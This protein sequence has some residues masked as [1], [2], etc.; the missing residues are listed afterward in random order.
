MSKTLRVAKNSLWLIVQPV[1]LNLLSLLAVPYIARV[2]GKADYGRFILGFAFV[3]MFSPLVNMG[4]RAITVRDLAQNR[5]SCREY[6][7]KMLGT[8]GLLGLAASGAV[9]VVV[10]I[11]GYDSSTKVVVYLAALAMLCE[12]VSGTLQDVFQAVEDM[13]YTAYSRFVGGFVLTVLSVVVVLAGWG[14]V[15]LTCS[16]LF[17][18]V[19]TTA[20]A[21][22]YAH[23]LM[24]SPSVAFDWAFTKASLVRGA[25]FFYP[26][27]VSAVAARIGVSLLPL[28]C[29]VAAVGA[30]GAASTLME[31]L[32]VIPDGICTAIYPSL[33]ATYKTS[34]EEAASLFRRYF[35]YLFL[36][37]LPVAV[38]ATLIAEPVIMLLF[39]KQYAAAAPVLAILSWWVFIMFLVQLLGWT[40]GAIQQE[41]RIAVVTFVTAPLGV[42]LTLALIPYFHEQGIAWAKVG[43][44]VLDLVLLGHCVR[45]TLTR[46]IL[47][48]RRLV[49]LVL[50]NALMGLLVGFVRNMNIAIP[51]AVGVLSYPVICLA[52]GVVS[53][54]ELSQLRALLFRRAASRVPEPVPDRPRG[55]KPQ[56]D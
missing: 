6:A 41:K 35:E 5:T 34:P 21:W 44:A 3:A 54:R 56:G 4:M 49:R 42:A 13:H 55:E 46:N 2:L 45:V 20:V 50:A 11:L 47:P 29:G 12:V 23:R 22:Y 53:V 10:N 51:L 24:G 7:S 32:N 38:G 19:L 27:V 18:S 25:P 40:L 37:G 52:T 17:G 31:R 36:L 1:L 43:T 48:L 26:I 39:G 8:R 33:A 9:A 14:L 28:Y 16:Y 15:G 30:Y